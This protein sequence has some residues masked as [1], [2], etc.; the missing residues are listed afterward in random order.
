[1]GKNKQTKKTVSGLTS[2]SFCHDF[3]GGD[4]IWRKRCESL[5]PSGL[6][7]IVQVAAA[8]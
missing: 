4:I 7:P 1:M 6:M 2:H 5:H 3:D 8:M